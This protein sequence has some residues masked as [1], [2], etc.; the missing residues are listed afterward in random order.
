MNKLIL[1]TDSDI[2][3]LPKIL[4]Y[5]DSIEYNSNFEDKLVLFKHKW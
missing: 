4:P 1:S 2:H 5:L 3:Y